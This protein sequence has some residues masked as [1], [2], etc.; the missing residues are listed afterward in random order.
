[1]H[2]QCQ[3]L[4]HTFDKTL[5]LSLA[6]EACQ[7]YHSKLHIRVMT[8][9]TNYHWFLYKFCYSVDGRVHHYCHIYL[10]NIYLKQ[11]CHLNFVCTI[12]R[13]R[14]SHSAQEFLHFPKILLFFSFCC[15]NRSDTFFL[16]LYIIIFIIILG[17]TGRLID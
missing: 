7:K 6:E 4:I 12:K 3:K 8:L 17:F 5:F 2:L 16:I 11:K 10:R 14:E 1:M 15:V 13:L 9:A